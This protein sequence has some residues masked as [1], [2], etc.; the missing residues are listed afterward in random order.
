MFR[1]FHS[2]IRFF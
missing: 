1:I 2:N